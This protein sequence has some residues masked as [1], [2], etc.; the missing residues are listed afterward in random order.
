MPLVSVI[1]PAYNAEKTIQ[2][3]INSVIAQ[4]FGDF[5]L[6]I[7]DDCSKDGT[8]EIISSFQ[9]KDERIVPLRNEQNSGAAATRNRG[10]SAARGEWI[11]FLDSDDI[12]RKDKLE[13]QMECLSKNREAVLCFT[14]SSFIDDAGN[15]YSYIMNVPQTVTYKQLLKGNSIS[16]SSVVI[17]S[18]LMKTLKMP[19][20]KMHEDYYIW[21]TV[22]KEYEFAYGINEPL[23]IYR[24]SSNSKSSSRTKSAKM[25]FNSY[26]AVGYNSLKSALYVFRYMFYSI[27]KRRAIKNS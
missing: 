9:S 4:T 5:E 24:L 8:F 17:K 22:L 11:A 27:K 21:L 23:L 10:V 25:L 26:K 20:D 19:N 12:W 15:E 3:A 18:S 13:K 1:M 7:I 6:I 16:C 14:A 2:S